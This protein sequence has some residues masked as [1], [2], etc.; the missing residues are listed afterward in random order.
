MVTSDLTKAY[1]V[2]LRVA[3]MS[4]QEIATLTGL[5]AG[6]IGMIFARAKQ[7]GFD[8]EKKPHTIDEFVTGGRGASQSPAKESS[9]KKAADNKSPSKKRKIPS[10]V[11]L[12]AFETKDHDSLA[13]LFRCRTWC[14][15]AMRPSLSTT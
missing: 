9:A 2:G 7:R 4:A 6:A 14:G 13:Y 5:T 3:G 8:P 10:K 12:N 1:V 15:Q 11:R